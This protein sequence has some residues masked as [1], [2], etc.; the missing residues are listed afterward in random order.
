LKR[1]FCEKARHGRAVARTLLELVRWAKSVKRI[2]IDNAR[3]VKLRETHSN[4]QVSEHRNNDR[5][6]QK[7]N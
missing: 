5:G 3:T 2:V 6:D 7:A 1:S 4:V